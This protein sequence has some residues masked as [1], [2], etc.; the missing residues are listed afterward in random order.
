M[1]VPKIKSTESF[2]ELVLKIFQLNA[3]VVKNV[4]LVQ[5]LPQIGG[6]EKEAWREMH[7]DC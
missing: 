5:F 3:G 6:C 4:H 2:R 7:L 1:A